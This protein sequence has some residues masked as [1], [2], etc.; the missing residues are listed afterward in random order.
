MDNICTVTKKYM[1]TTKQFFLLIIASI[2]VFA[3][4]KSSS[5]SNKIDVSNIY[6]YNNQGDLIHVQPN[7]QWT[8]IPLTSMELAL[9]Q[10]ID[11]AV[12]PNTN[13]PS[14]YLSDTIKTMSSIFYP[15]PIHT[16]GVISFSGYTPWV[17]SHP[18]QGNLF[19]KYIVVDSLLEIMDKGVVSMRLT[20]SRTIPFHFIPVGRFRLY[21]TLSALGNENF[22]QGWSNIQVIQ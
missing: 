2:I 1:M 9:F 11:T 3:C 5:S 6:K 13:I 22:Y 15:N 17:Y 4:N 8:Y 20:D 14:I 21:Y 10:G 12:L 18:I 7:G 16:V 19:C